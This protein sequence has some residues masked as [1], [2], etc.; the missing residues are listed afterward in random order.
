MGK[1]DVNNVKMNTNHTPIPS[2][3]SSSSKIRKEENLNKRCYY[4][5]FAGD[6]IALSMYNKPLNL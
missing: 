1:C 4:T 3:C 5:T 6:V 2:F